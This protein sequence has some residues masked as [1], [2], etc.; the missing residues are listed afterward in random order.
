[1]G[2]ILQQ[3]IFY[4][5][6]AILL[7]SAV[8]VVIS[9]NPVRAVLF[10]VLGFFCACVLWML[11]QAEF[12]ALV[13]IFVY[14]GA[15]MTLFL[16]VIMMLNLDI[17]PARKGW[18]PYVPLAV[19]LLGLL[20]IAV[21]SALNP[22]HFDDAVYQVISQPENYSNVKQIGA[23]LY[24]D[25]FYPFELAAI[26]LLVAIVSAICLAFRGKRAG[27]KSQRISQQVAVKREERVRLVKFPK[28]KK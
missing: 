7:F 10:L 14:I 24:T 1:M 17:T 15:V 20:V 25:Y 12:L 8:M 3:V 2:L 13:L 27:G 9:V 28:E 5:F 26:L 18:I 23:V 6:A 11:L 19:L 16:F 22:E 4:A 21:I